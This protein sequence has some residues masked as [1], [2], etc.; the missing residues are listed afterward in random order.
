M[1][2]L[3]FKINYLCRTLVEEQDRA[4]KQKIK[5]VK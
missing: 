2:I 4:S 1:T 5:Y 3:L